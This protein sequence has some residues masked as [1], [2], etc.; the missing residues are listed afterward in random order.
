MRSSAIFLCLCLFIPGSSASY[1]QAFA[2]NGPASA[3]IPPVIFDGLHQL[4]NQKPEEVEKAWFRGALAEEAAVPSDLT[5][6]LAHNTVGAYQDFDVVSVQD[7]TPRMRI[8]YLALN[9]EKNSV[10]VKFVLYRTTDGWILRYHKVG[11]DEEIF[12]PAARAR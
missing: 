2:A 10:M 6:Y 8:L 3:K 12:E 1:S 11:I 4:A 7:L 5:D 9:F